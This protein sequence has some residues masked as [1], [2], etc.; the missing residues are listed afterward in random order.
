MK[1]QLK[2]LKY[3]NKIIRIDNINEN[4]KSDKLKI[5]DINVNF[6]DPFKVP[7]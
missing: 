1:Q 4:L 2:K 5:I 7:K 3:T 6:T